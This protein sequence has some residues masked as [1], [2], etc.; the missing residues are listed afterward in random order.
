M[1]AELGSTLDKHCNGD[2][3]IEL[4]KRDSKT[5]GVIRCKKQVRSIGKMGGD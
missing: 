3:E 5:S 4:S 2:T 1:V